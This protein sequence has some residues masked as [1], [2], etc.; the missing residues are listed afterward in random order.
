MTTRS[1]LVF[2]LVV[3][4]GSGSATTTRYV[5]T[6]GFRTLSTDTPASTYIEERVAK[7]GGFSRSLFSG[8]A[9]GGLIKPNYGVLTLSNEDGGLDTIATYAGGGGTV[10]CW[11]GEDGAAFP[12]GYTQVYVATI[13]SVLVDFETVVIRQQDRFEQ[14]NRPVVTA[15]FAGTGSIEGTDT[16]ARKKQIVFGSPGMIPLILIDKVNQVYCVQANATDRATVAGLAEFGLVFEGGVPITRAAPYAFKEYLFLDSQ[17][18]DPGEFRI[19]SGYQG[20]TTGSITIASESAAAQYTKGPIYVRLG[21][22]PVGELRFGARGLL[23]NVSSTPA[24]EWRFSDLCNRAGLNDVS[25]STMATM[26]NGREDFTAG[27]RLIDGEQT[28]AQVM[29]DRCQAVLGAAGFTRLNEFFCVSLTD[30]EDGDDTSAYSFTVDNSA[31]FRRLPVPGMERPVWQVNVKSGRAWPCTVFSGASAE[32]QDLLTRE[33]HY[34]AFRGYSSTTRRRYPNAMSIDLE[35]EG[36]D[37]P[38]SSDQRTFV[39]RFGKLFG[40][41]RDLMTLRC[42]QFDATTLALELHDKATLTLD[43]LGYDAGVVMRIVGI[44]LDLDA[45]SIKFSLWGN[46][47]DWDGW[48]LTGGAFPADAGEPGGSWGSEDPPPDVVTETNVTL[49][50]NEQM[51]AFTGLIYGGPIV[52][53]VPVDATSNNAAMGEFTGTIVGEA[54]GFVCLD[55]PAWTTA[56]LPATTSYPA[57]SVAVGGTVA[58]A[59]SNSSGQPYAVYSL[60]AGVTWY[61]ASITGF[62]G[63]PGGAYAPVYL[64]G[65]WFAKVN[66]IEGMRS[67]DG[68]NW[69]QVS[70]LSHSAD[71]TGYA[72]DKFLMIANSDTTG[73]LYSSDASTWTLSTGLPT[74]SGSVTNCVDNGTVAVIA[75]LDGSS[76]F[77]L[78]SS[79]GISWTKNSA[80]WTIA[81]WSVACNGSRFVVVGQSSSTSD[82]GWYSDDGVTW[83]SMS[84]V[85]T[86]IGSNIWKDVTYNGGLF[87]AVSSNTTDVSISEDGITWALSANPMVTSGASSVAAV[88]NN[89][90]AQRQAS[91]NTIRIGSCP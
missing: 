85:G 14:L 8:S 55:G 20:L 29:S 16:A 73:I 44:E 63:T 21:G 70:H 10:T 37:F 84:L 11:W 82:N 61:A 69:A 49:G 4:T 51:G 87:L 40:T 67:T 38:D 54:S 80:P 25:S 68:Q 46:N 1:R 43:R 5:T 26:Q 91:L 52:V 41:R 19:W 31:D 42:L 7:A 6:R 71:R 24:R 34:I 74:W 27:N 9:M 3:P 64:N 47:T 35:I 33:G 48:S 56:T 28:Y 30:P 79:D 32:M 18:P 23:Q 90:I 65:T 75:G 88:D 15:T 13:A 2:K 17:A 58:V 50:I 89:Y 45:M 39:D 76:G 66:A 83:T 62:T 36:H 77:S 22:I 60:D 12:A 53:P 81:P 57:Y 72:F 78:T 59:V 86:G